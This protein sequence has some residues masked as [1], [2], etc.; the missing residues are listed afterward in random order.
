LLLLLLLFFFFFF[1]LYSASFESS[2]SQEDSQL[3]KDVKNKEIIISFLQ[4]TDISM[5]VVCVP[6]VVP[7][8]LVS[9]HLLGTWILLALGKIIFFKWK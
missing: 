9:S 7:Y 8:L 6:Q 1:F 3:K 4:R 5:F 2:G